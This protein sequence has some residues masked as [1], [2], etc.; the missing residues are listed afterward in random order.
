MGKITKEDIVQTAD[1]ARLAV[2]GTEAEQYSE[3]LTKI[4]NF[5][6]KINEINTDDVEP[7]THGIIGKNVLR[8]DIPET[9]IT[10]EDALANAPD[11]EDN[12]FK[13]LPIIE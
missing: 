8:A 10:R 9:T 13:V 4:L 1:L 5:V 12:Q 11:H 6:K 2:T 7:T 3:D